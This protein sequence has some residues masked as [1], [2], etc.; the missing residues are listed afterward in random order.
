MG[1]EKKRDKM[2]EWVKKYEQRI[3]KIKIPNED[4]DTKS[5]KKEIPIRGVNLDNLDGF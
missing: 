3:P 1:Y 5:P 2:I 4:G